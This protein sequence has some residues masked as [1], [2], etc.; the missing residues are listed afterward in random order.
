[1]HAGNKV[2]NGNVHIHRSPTTKYL[3]IGDGIVGLPTIGLRCTYISF[4]ADGKL[5]HKRLSWL[6]KVSM[7]E[8][9]L[10]CYTTCFG[11]RFSRHAPSTTELISAFA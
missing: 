5:N 6:D 9:Y 8:K 4:E 10:L 7:I 2:E 1:M 11:F 3:H